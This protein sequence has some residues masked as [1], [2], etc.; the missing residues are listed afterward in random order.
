MKQKIILTL[1][2]LCLAIAGI[3]AIGMGSG[4]TGFVI[5][6]ASQEITVNQ[7]FSASFLFLGLAIFVVGLLHD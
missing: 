4:L 1:T 5:A 3:F 7:I 2:F 6:D